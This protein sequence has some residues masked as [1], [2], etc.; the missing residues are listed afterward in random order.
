M[1][2]S[3]TKTINAGE[4]AVYSGGRSVAI[5]AATAP[6]RLV[7]YDQFGQMLCDFDLA[8]PG[9]QYQLPEPAARFEVTSYSD[10]NRVTLAA[11]STG[12]LLDAHGDQFSDPARMS[13][14]G[15]IFG[16]GLRVNAGSGNYGACCLWNA[17]D[18]GKNLIIKR[19]TID[20]NIAASMS[21][22]LYSSIAAYSEYSTSYKSCIVSGE[23][24]PRGRIYSRVSGSSLVIGDNR[25]KYFVSKNTENWD[26][27]E[28]S[29][30]PPIV[31]P[32][33]G[34]FVGSFSSNIDMYVN[35]T[36]QEIDA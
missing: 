19:L 32:G 35:Y 15:N 9:F 14:S 23:S 7:G 26:I 10:A 21:L 29:E 18:T 25:L 16:G 28:E 33:Y 8:P 4:V 27:I 1:D 11:V 30:P 13:L 6:V 2:R 31:K 17:A 34:L 12:R 3:E 5:L 36:W 20:N 24:G 22:F